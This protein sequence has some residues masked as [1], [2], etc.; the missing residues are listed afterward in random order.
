[1]RVLAGL[2]GAALVALTLQSAIRTVVVPRAESVA[3]T[4]AV[5]TSTRRLFNTLARLRND[6]AWVDR[7]MRLYAPVVLLALP[8]VWLAM[9]FLAFAMLLWAVGEGTFPTALEL[10]GSSL[11]TLGFSKPETAAGLLLAYVGAALTIA[12]VVLLL[13][14]YLPT[15]YSAFAERERQVTM[16]ETRAGTPP[17]AVEFITRVGRIHGLHELDDVWRGWEVWFAT[18]Q[19]SHS[20]QP[21]LAFFRSQRPQVSWITA[22]GA[23]LDAASLFVSC[24]ELSEV[25]PRHQ[26]RMPT[27]EVCIRSGFL[28]LRTI[29]ASFRL[30]FDPD[31]APDDGIAIGRDEFDTAWEAL[32]AAGIPLVDDRDAAWRAFAGW[33]V[34]YE[35]PLLRLADLVAAP[36]TPW[37]S[38][39]RPVTRDRSGV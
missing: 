6:P 16:L 37:V 29:A 18:V 15:M 4:Q 32:E 31:P 17:S 8:L 26:V 39:R 34:N 23:L 13:V 7:V 9:F 36:V 38:D 35:E 5:F 20:S 27:A 12:I 24:V 3:I 25:E 2:G 19:E 22:A 33:R 21:A 14:T 10:S 11:L 1:M 28:C 30:P